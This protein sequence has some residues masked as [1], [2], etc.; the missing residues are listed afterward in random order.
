MH[1]LLENADNVHYVKLVIERPPPCRL[2]LVMGRDPEAVSCPAE[3]CEVRA[4][5][6]TALNLAAL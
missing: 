4:L 6:A 1:T 5:V 2:A 3:G